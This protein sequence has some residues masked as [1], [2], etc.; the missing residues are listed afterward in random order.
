MMLQALRMLIPGGFP[1]SSAAPSIKNSFSPTQ[2]LSV[3]ECEQWAPVTFYLRLVT[4][5]VIGKFRVIRHNAKLI[6]L[7]IG[8]VLLVQ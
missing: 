2:R 7:D 4:S 1:Y 8:T 6:L 5:N 3:P